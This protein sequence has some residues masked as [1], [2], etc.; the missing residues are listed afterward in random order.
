MIV[1]PKSLVLEINKLYEN[2]IAKG[3]G[4]GWSNLDELFSVKY[5]EFTVITGMPSHGKSEWLD[6]LDRK[7]TRLNSSH[8]DISRMPSSA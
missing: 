6:A 1:N 4:T 8:T 3:H 7:S 5:G 2:G